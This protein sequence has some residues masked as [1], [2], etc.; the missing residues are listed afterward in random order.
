MPDEIIY[1]SNKY[2]FYPQSELV[3]REDYVE[4]LQKDQSGLLFFT[5]SEKDEAYAS[6]R[7]EL[8][9]LVSLFKTIRKEGEGTPLGVARVSISTSELQDVLQKSDIT[10]EGVVYLINNRGEILTSSNDENLML[11]KEYGELPGFGANTSWVPMELGKSSYLMKQQTI[12]TADWTVTALAPEREFYRQSRMMGITVFAVSAIMVMMIVLISYFLANYY[13]S[14]LTRLNLTMKAVEEGNVNVVFEGADEEADEVGDLFRRFNRMTSEV[15]RLMKDQYRLGKTVKSAELR[16]LQA[17][18]NPH[19][20]YNTL[21]LINWEAMDY[22]APEIAEIAQSLAQFY[23]ISLNKGRQIVTI[24]EELNHVKAYVRI[25]RY[26]FDN[27]IDLEVSVPEEL[28]PFTCINIILQPFVE[29]SIMYGIAKNPDMEECRILITARRLGGDIEFMVG[30][31]GPG[32]TPEQMAAILEKNTYHATHG[33]GAKNINFRLKLCYG[34]EYGIRY[35]SEPG[36]GTRVY[37]RIPA[38]TPE[39]AEQRIP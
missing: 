29:N 20:L 8:R 25:E 34:E 28:L 22:D 4:F 24:E 32:M 21:D 38:L 10:R 30:D 39:E 27:A 1:S 31:D 17:Q 36:K 3:T 7:D 6:S 2:H 5:G 15:R 23:R 14:R 35:E 11:L 9:R 26:H 37:I 33:Y 19:F 12:D 16:A 13:T 18:I